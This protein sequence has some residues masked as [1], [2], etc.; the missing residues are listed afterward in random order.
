MTTH[1]SILSW[2]IS[3]TEEPG[4][5]QSMRSQTV[6]HDLVTKNKNPDTTSY[7][8]STIW[9]VYITFLSLF[10][11][12]RAAL[13]ISQCLAQ[14]T[15]VKVA[16]LC[17]TLCNPMDCIGLNSPGQNTGVGSLSL[18]QGIFPTQGSNPGVLHCRQ[19]LY[20]LSH[21]GTI[22]FKSWILSFNI[23]IVALFCV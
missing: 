10:L 15:K 1:S 13:F 17:L 22:F 6:R 11:T 14:C 23:F 18:L 7:K 21:K 8:H 5:L 2:E 20:Q 9:Y 3:W 12:M 16:Q 19:I 4:S